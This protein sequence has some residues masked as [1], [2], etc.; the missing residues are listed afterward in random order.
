MLSPAVLGL[1]ALLIQAPAFAQDSDLVE[2]LAH[3]ERVFPESKA[4]RPFGAGS[5]SS[6]YSTEA[7]NSA[8]S[9]DMEARI[10]AEIDRA[11]DN[12]LRLRRA[13]V[14]CRTNTCAVLLVHATG[15]GEGTVRNLLKSFR[16]T[17][18]FGGVTKEEASVPLQYSTPDGVTR[19]SFMSG[20]VDVLLTFGA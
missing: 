14:E 17:L 3:A 5:L 4:P 11:R 15:S 19:T 20:Y 12:G 10:F 7:V 8:W 2:F 9:A 13:E 16:S 6:A 1:T 18:G